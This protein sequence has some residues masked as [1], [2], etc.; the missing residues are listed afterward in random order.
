[1]MTDESFVHHR[2]ASLSCSPL[3]PE[4]F[5][6]SPV[7]VDPNTLMPPV[8]VSMCPSRLPVAAHTKTTAQSDEQT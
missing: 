7:M 6:G 1:M 2:K 4:I 8:S 3:I 5:S